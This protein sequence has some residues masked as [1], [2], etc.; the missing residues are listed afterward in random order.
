MFIPAALLLGFI[1]MVQ[2]SRLRR[3]TAAAPA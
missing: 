1:V 3:E 2:R